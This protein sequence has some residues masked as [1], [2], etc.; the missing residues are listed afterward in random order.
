M[1]MPFTV[2]SGGVAGAAAGVG[3]VASG[4]LQPA[5]ATISAAA[6]KRMTFI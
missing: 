6:K 4:L 3:A 1:A 2:T 5:S